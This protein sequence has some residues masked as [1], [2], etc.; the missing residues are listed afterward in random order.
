MN[1]HE[2]DQVNIRWTDHDVPHIEAQN[3]ASLGF[4]YGYVHARDRLCEL[5]GQVITLRGERSKHYGAERFSTIGF[6]KTTNLNSDLMFRLR[7]PPEWVENELAKLGTQTREY[8]QGYV[9][10]LNHYVDQMPADEKE[11]WRA[12][13][14]LVTFTEQDVV[15]AAMRFGIMKELVEI[16]PH[17]ISSAQQW[18]SESAPDTVDSP[19]ATPV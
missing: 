9:R 5:S 13:E 15:R 3:Y 2:L 11:R 16:G 4:G 18:R 1:Q 19:H 14:P 8:V 7:L 6:L 17:L 12:D 10:G